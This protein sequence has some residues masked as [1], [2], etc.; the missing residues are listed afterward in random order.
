MYKLYYMPGACSLATQVVLRELGQEFEIF[1]KNKLPDFTEINP[2]GAVPALVE[3][4]Q[5]LTEGAAILLH[6]LDKHQNQMLPQS[7]QGRQKA[8]EDI[9]FANATMHPAYSKLFFLSGNMEDSETKA[10]A[11]DA[12]AQNITRLWGLVEL[13]LGENKFLGGENPSAADVL[14]AV[15]STWGAYF[16]VNIEIGPKTRKM[17]DAITS[18]PS[19][20]DSVQAEQ[21]SA[22]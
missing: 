6:L 18:M 1:D 13:K 5:V 9:M 14:L 3:N 10:K 19:F 7:G 16:D 15:Y 8:I 12:V 4:D 21:S 20:I 17:I 2:T 11:L 22:A